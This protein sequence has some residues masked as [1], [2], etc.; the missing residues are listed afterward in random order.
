MMWWNCKNG[1]SWIYG[2]NQTYFL[3]TDMLGF[4]NGTAYTFYA[5]ANNTDGNYGMET[6]TDNFNITNNTIQLSSL[7]S[8]R[9]QGSSGSRS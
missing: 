7:Y 1:S 8:D 2:S 9:G 6:Y 5:W 3:P 4:V